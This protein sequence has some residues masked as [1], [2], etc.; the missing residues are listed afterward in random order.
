MKPRTLVAALAIA[1]LTVV[2]AGCTVD[3]AAPVA[4]C[5]PVAGTVTTALADDRGVLPAEVWLPVVTSKG[6]YLPLLKPLNVAS[7]SLTTSELEAILAAKGA[8]RDAAVATA[9]TDIPR[10]SRKATSL[11][12]AATTEPVRVNRWAPPVVEEQ[13][14]LLVPSSVIGKAVGAFYAAALERQGY[15][16]TTR[17]VTAEEA[18]TRATSD[19]AGHVALLELPDL[20]DALGAK[21]PGTGL[22]GQVQAAATAA[23]K[24]SLAL[25]TPTA[26]NRTPRV[27]VTQGFAAANG[28]VTDL[29]GLAAACPGIVVAATDDTDDKLAALTEPYGL[30]TAMCDDGAVDWVRSGLTVAVLAPAVNHAG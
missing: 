18:L 15:T 5:Q 14:Q 2:S 8:D 7:R 20:A 16:V 1:T 9:V 29:S 10:A 3:A 23:V 28:N 27:V 12:G 26:A 22:S 6:P 17:T 30:R 4:P 25:G 13:Y 11:P 21:L 19:G 24:R